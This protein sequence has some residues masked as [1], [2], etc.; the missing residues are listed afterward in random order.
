MTVSIGY[1]SSTTSSSGPPLSGAFSRNR[2]RTGNR[3]GAIRHATSM[4]GLRSIASLRESFASHSRKNSGGGGGGTVRG[5]NSTN[6]LLARS[7]RDHPAAVGTTARPGTSGDDAK[8]LLKDER[9][10][11]AGRQLAGPAPV[12]VAG[13]SYDNVPILKEPDVRMFRS[14]PVTPTK[15]VQR[16]YHHQR[17]RQLSYISDAGAEDYTSSGA[18]TVTENIRPHGDSE[19][20]DLDTAF[21]LSTL[22]LLHSESE[23]GGEEA[24]GDHPSPSS[25]SPIG[26][27]QASGDEDETTL[28]SAEP[29]SAQGHDELEEKLENT[30]RNRPRSP[31]YD[32]NG[33]S[34]IDIS[35]S[36]PGRELQA[37]LAHSDSPRPT[38]AGSSHPSLAYQA[39]LCHM[40][41]QLTTLQATNTALMTLKAAQ[42]DTIAVHESTIADHSEKMSTQ[43]AIISRHEGTISHLSRQLRSKDAEQASL[44]ENFCAE[45]M[46]NNDERALL[47]E[48]KQTMTVRVAELEEKVVRL[49]LEL[50]MSDQEADTSRRVPEN[51]AG[52]GAWAGKDL[53]K[54]HSDPGREQSSDCKDDSTLL[55]SSSPIAGR[56]ESTGGQTHYPVTIPSPLF[57]PRPRSGSVRALYA[58]TVTPTPSARGAPSIRVTGTPGDDST[59]PPVGRQTSTAFSLGDRS[60]VTGDGL[61]AMSDRLGEHL[62]H[63]SLGSRRVATRSVLLAEHQA[64]PEQDLA[65]PHEKRRAAEGQS[66]VELQERALFLEALV[67]KLTGMAAIPIPVSLPPP[68]IPELHVLTYTNPC[69]VWSDRVKTSFR[70]LG[71]IDF[72]QPV[73][74]V[75]VESTAAELAHWN[76]RRLRAAV[77]L[78]HAVDDD[79]LEDVLD[80][81]GK[82]D[83]SASAHGRPGH[84]LPGSE[85]P[86]R[87]FSCILTLRQTVPTSPTDLT[88]VDR[89]DGVDFDG[90]EEF[91]ALVLCLDKRHSIMYGTSADHYEALFPIIQE[92]IARRFPDLE[93]TAFAMDPPDTSPRKWWQLSVWMAKMIKW[94]QMSADP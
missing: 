34:S 18:S 11:S 36:P 82:K 35:S 56:P 75:P 26:A 24:Q 62:D 65:A 25:S 3:T 71:L 14:L 52:A 76:S 73:A 46:S 23:Q 78:K 48:E 90:I 77:L 66:L 92:N 55:G 38:T 33:W 13:P 1:P 28:T 63:Y 9:E 29:I 2:N 42:E 31:E 68:P 83:A 70:Y 8:P 79:I 86:H 32:M 41:N 69:S 94:R 21:S 12:S 51:R 37:Q 49:E 81:C 88:W 5:R 17:H 67:Q 15:Q 53:E 45:M 59:L 6:H 50:N 80:I 19:L 60:E 74:P 40:Q 85:N 20:L 93:Q 44:V 4:F 89:I 10:R 47:K 27:R 30:D 22:Y 54:R 87:L 39:Q 91:A 58:A 43:K 84:G 61:G 72:I 57:S 16:M 7:D 64:M